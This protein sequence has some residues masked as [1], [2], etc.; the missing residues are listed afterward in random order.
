M[1][2]NKMTRQTGTFLREKIFRGH[3]RIKTQGI[4]AVVKKIAGGAVDSRRPPRNVH[5]MFLYLQTQ[6]TEFWNMMPDSI[7]IVRHWITWAITQLGECS[8]EVMTRDLQSRI[9]ERFS[10]RLSLDPWLICSSE[11]TGQSLDPH[12]NKMLEI[13]MQVVEDVVYSLFPLVPKT[14]LTQT[15]PSFQSSHRQQPKRPQFTS[16]FRDLEPLPD[17]YTEEKLSEGE[18]ERYENS[19]SSV[20]VPTQNHKGLSVRLKRFKKSKNADEETKKKKEKKEEKRNTEWG[21]SDSS[22]VSDEEV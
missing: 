9:W 7:P 14:I 11:N 4:D 1:S 8:E 13:F 16:L 15:S 20:Y 18:H 19:T 17:E 6:T 3:L 12:G 5:E 22:S 10:Q 21:D 2:Y